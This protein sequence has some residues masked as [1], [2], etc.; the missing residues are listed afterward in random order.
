VSVKSGGGRLDLGFVQEEFKK[1][2]ARSG[3]AYFRLQPGDNRLRIVP[4]DTDNGPRMYFEE[5]LH[6]FGQGQ[7]PQPC[8]GASCP[9]CAEAAKLATSPVGADQEAGKRL[10]ATSM[11]RRLV[12]DRGLP[13]AEQRLCVAGFGRG[14]AGQLWDILVNKEYGPDTFAHKGGRDV[15][16]R[17]S[18]GAKPMD[19][20]KVLPSP[21]TSDVPDNLIAR[22]VNLEATGGQMPDVAEA[23]AAPE[24]TVPA[25]QEKQRGRPR[26][27]PVKEAEA[28]PPPPAPAPPVKEA[29]KPACFGQFDADDKDYCGQCGLAK[30]CSG[31]G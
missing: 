5:R 18:K 27:K 14:V 15:T 12:I 25:V 3:G 31:Q 13:E 23:P 21:R 1:S 9:H 2:K 20:Y 11:F 26:S 8:L 10:R 24:A 19:I 7:Q 30:A 4:F 17:Y 16:I 28:S 6:F 29:E 22:I